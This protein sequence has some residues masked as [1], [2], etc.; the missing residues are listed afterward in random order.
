MTSL[1]RAAPASLQ[2]A[3][4]MSSTCQS[5]PVIPPQPLHPQS[6]SPCPPSTRLSMDPREGESSYLQVPKQVLEQDVKATTLEPT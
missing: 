2:L 4:T 5:L 6:L 3:P 1:T